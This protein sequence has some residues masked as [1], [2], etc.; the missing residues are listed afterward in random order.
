[1]ASDGSRPDFQK[2]LL[3]ILDTAIEADNASKGNL[4]ILD[5]DRRTLKIAAQRGF[6][7]Q[8]LQTFR[9]VR[10]DEPCACG[11]AF[12]QKRRVVV[13]NVEADSAYA[14]Y[15]SLAI[16]SG[17]RAVQSTPVIADD[18]E[19]VGMLS[20]HFPRVHR[21]SKAARA[22]LDQCASRLAQ[23]LQKLP[24]GPHSVTPL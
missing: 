1:M 24:R 19:V 22:T 5:P 23:V 16:A 13:S 4:Q 9:N 8:F 20:T 2:S 14:P 17:Y 18:G 15:V 12:R 6:D 3:E 7:T 11:R 10:A 21:L